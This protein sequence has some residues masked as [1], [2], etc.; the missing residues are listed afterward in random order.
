[1][2]LYQLRVAAALLC[3]VIGG[4]FWAWHAI[5]TAVDEK[6]QPN[7]GRRVVRQADLVRPPRTDLYGD[8]LPPG[9]AM[10]LGTVRFRKATFIS[11][12]VYSPDGQFVVTAAERIASTSMGCAGWQDTAPD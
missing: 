12:L 1:M 4:S 2:L 8:P 10:R 7:L 5:A 9:A 6:D 3:L 11:H